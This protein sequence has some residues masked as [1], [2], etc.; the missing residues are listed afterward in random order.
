MIESHVEK[1]LGNKI[2]MISGPQKNYKTYTVTCSGTWWPTMI[3]FSNIDDEIN[4]MKERLDRT[5][6]R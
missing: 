6:I 2:K 4:W 3:Q 5:D 1:T